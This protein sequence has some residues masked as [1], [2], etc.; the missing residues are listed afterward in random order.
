MTSRD[1][2]I[3]QEHRA[4]LLGLAYR[5]L[6]SKSDAEDVLQDIF[7]KWYQQPKS[8]IV[9]PKAWLTTICTRQSIDLLRSAYKSRTEYIGTWLPEPYHAEDDMCIESDFTL[10]TMFLLLLEKLSAKERAAYLL[11]DIFDYDY[12]ELSEILEEN[13]NY[14]RKLIS[15]AREKVVFEH[16]L[17]FTPPTSQQIKILHVFQHAVQSGNPEQLTAL[18]TQDVHLFAD[19]GGKVS[20]ISK[21]LL[22]IE[23]V[24]QFFEKLLF[25]AWHAFQW[26][27]QRINGNIGFDFF[28]AHGKCIMVVTFGFSANQ[29][30]QNIYIQR[31]PDKIKGQ[32]QVALY[33][34]RQNNYF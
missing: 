5:I 27:L 12:S 8:D 34:N 26:K 28:D 16:D 32:H 1:V 2:E 22:S 10:S 15:R 31:N 19:G 17:S 4:F 7:I 24:T 9:T 3:F 21:P 29:L 18:L 33:K 25:Q 14:C 6:G 23:Q 20:A 30:I 11:H 13:Q